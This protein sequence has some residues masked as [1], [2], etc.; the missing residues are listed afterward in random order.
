MQYVESPKTLLVRA[1][2]YASP[3]LAIRSSSSCK[4]AID[5]D[6][7]ALSLKSNYLRYFGLAVTTYGSFFALYP[8]RERHQNIRALYYSN[9][10]RAFPL[11]TAYTIFDFVFVLFVSAATT[12]VLSGTFAH[13][14]SLSH[15]FIVLA[16]Y[17]LTSLL[18]SYVVSL[19]AKSQLAAFAVAAGSQAIM[20]LVYIIAFLSISTDSSRASLD[21]SLK[22]A[23]YLLSLVLPVGSLAR[24]ILVSLNTLSVSCRGTTL[25][26]YPGDIDAYGGPILYLI[27]QSGL[28]FGFLVWWDFGSRIDLLAKKDHIYP[29][30]QELDDIDVVAEAHRSVDSNDPL[31]VLHAS[32]SFSGKSVVENV[33][34]GVAESEVFALLGPNGAGK[35]T[36]MALIRGELPMSDTRGEVFVQGIALSKHL[37]SLRAHLG[38]CPQF[39]AI[40]DM[41]VIEH[42]RLYAEIKGV[43]DIDTSVQHILTSM[44]LAQFAQ[45]MASQL[46]GGYKRR[47]SLGMAVIGMV[48][49]ILLS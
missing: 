26:S 18:L 19:F 39:D 4:Y 45:R 3:L 10:L 12:I 28:L 1:D 25:I 31:R 13:W 36:L 6:L 46:S 9:G 16:L 47:L 40:D 29:E 8:T 35:T 22:L 37:S 41:T 24:A 21:S 17:G 38:F 23:H 44:G 5:V 33:T 14:Y 7:P 30:D 49:S 48:F 34:F 32:K 15:L 42:L 20:Y 11:W 43:D 27:V 2:Q